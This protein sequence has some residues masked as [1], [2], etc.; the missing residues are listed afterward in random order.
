MPETDEKRRA[1]ILDSV[2]KLI[3]LDLSDDEIIKNLRDV[4]INEKE[5]KELIAQAKAEGT[6][7][8]AKVPSENRA[9][10]DFPSGFEGK[11]V[12]LW[13]NAVI[14]MVNKK[15]DEKTAAQF[16]A[17]KNKFIALIDS[18]IVFTT[19]KVMSDI[20]QR[21]KEM[22]EIL[23]AKINEIKTIAEKHNQVVEELK[24]AIADKDK[25]LEDL[26]EAKKNV[27]KAKEEA[28][29]LKESIEKDVKERI[30]E[31]MKEIDEKS[32]KMAREL[33]SVTLNKVNKLEGDLAS[34][35]YSIKK[36]SED[37]RA[38]LE[39]AATDIKARITKDINQLME[40]KVGEAGQEINVI[41]QTLVT[42]V[43]DALAKS[44]M[45]TKQFLR[46]AQ[47][48]V[49]RLDTRVV[50][51]LELESEVIED[52]L[53]EAANHIESMK[54][55]TRDE[56]VA[57]I[58]K[59]LEE[60]EALKRDINPE[61]IKAKMTELEQMR[62]Q[63]PK[64]I[65]QI[66]KDK[67]GSLEKEYTAR[68]SAKISEIESKM[69]ETED[70]VEEIVH[71]ADLKAKELEKLDE[72]LN[73]KTISH[74]NQMEKDYKSRM[75][76][77]TK[78]IEA[79]KK[80]Y[81]KL[82][83]DTSKLKEELAAAKVELENEAKSNKE[84]LL[85]AIDKIRAEEKA[86]VEEFINGIESGI[87][88]RC[89]RVLKGFEG[90]TTMD[91]NRLKQTI[92]RESLKEMQK[93]LEDK[94]EEFEKEMKDLQQKISKEAASLDLEK[95]KSEVEA[96]TVFREQFVKVLDG[97]IEKFNEKIQKFNETVN[98]MDAQY[99]ERVKLIDEKIE[100]LNKFEKNF[101]KIIGLSL[102]TLVEKK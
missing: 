8:K 36:V 20:E 95:V 64:D 39:N 97:H 42:E 89:E 45:D 59:H 2:K 72:V 80:N 62:K 51:T 17:E 63:I 100:E 16:E 44:R 71:S 58:N 55:S 74:I 76:E 1:I 87:I 31:M 52:L 77:L 30:A 88:K 27:D 48:E 67:L 54:I 13:Q 57:E 4:G 98:Q 78:D 96:V 83:E 69:A 82:I 29:M 101:A 68:I 70:V 73:T 56:L 90:Y 33:S 38:E 21:Q 5:A 66:A 25:F 93:E 46:K 22:E 61:A 94:K 50:K 28:E 11:A 99:K 34:M 53:K 19:Q 6:E 79:A 102:D 65:E 41:K 84:F 18:K 23:T 85:A 26:N 75:N 43:E 12:E 40:K 91:L 9:G 3:S 86:R 49:S 32:E 47:Q 7:T 24:E 81:S 15:I 92:V 10:R 60:L 35:R 14:N 37:A